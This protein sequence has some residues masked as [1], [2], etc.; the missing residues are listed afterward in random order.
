MVIGL[1]SGC[2]TKNILDP[3]NPVTLTLWHNYGQQTNESMNKM[4]EEFNG[5]VG[6]DKGVIVRIAYVADTREINERLIMAAN[7]DPGAPVLPDIAIIYP[8]IGV[9]FAEMDL[10][11][12]ISAQF[13]AEELATYIPAFLEEGKLGG[14]A[15]YII[16]IA[17]STEV[18]YVNATIF[19]RFAAET[20]VDYSNLA[21][22]EGIT[23]AAEKY[24]EWSGGK[25]FFYPLELF[26]YAMI[27]F[28]QLG[29]EFITGGSLNFSSPVFNGYGMYITQTP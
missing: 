17:K 6:E 11:A 8:R 13:T 15:V 23:D 4:V 21:T 22:F 27:G 18:L 2:E 10:L 24:Y 5:T 28:Q 29:E 26:N 1:F 20:G 3:K 14:D 12:D 19:D 25:A 16:P 7:K 9:T